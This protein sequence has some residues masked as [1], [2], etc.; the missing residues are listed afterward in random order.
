MGSFIST[1]DGASFESHAAGVLNVIT[2]SDLTVQTQFAPCTGSVTCR[3]LT[4]VAA[5]VSNTVI[6]ASINSEGELGV[7]VTYRGTDMQVEFPHNLEAPTSDDIQL[8]WDS[9]GVARIVYDGLTLTV[10]T[11]GD[12]LMLATTLDD[13]FS[14]RLDGVLGNNDGDVIDDFNFGLRRPDGSYDDEAYEDD[15]VRNGFMLK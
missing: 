10:A 13:T 2:T 11:S 1:F 14:A 12:E 8:D 5:E 4:E 9:D 6:S 7:T 3:R 15:D